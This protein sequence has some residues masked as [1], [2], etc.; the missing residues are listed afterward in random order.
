MGKGFTEGIILA[1]PHVNSYVVNGL[2]G[3]I[4][5]ITPAFPSF[6]L[7]STGAPDRRQW[8]AGSTTTT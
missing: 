7:T 1:V 2:T 3:A 6:L 5:N 8:I 4:S